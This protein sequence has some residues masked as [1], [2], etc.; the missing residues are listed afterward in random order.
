M[1]PHLWTKLAF[2]ISLLFFT[3][4]LSWSQTPPSRS[5]RVELAAINQPWMFNRLGASN[6]F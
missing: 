5:I 2:S 4:C 6:D 1:K 3:V